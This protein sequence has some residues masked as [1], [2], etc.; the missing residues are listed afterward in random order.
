MVAKRSNLTDL[1]GE[2]PPVRVNRF[3]G[4]G[5]PLMIRQHVSGTLPTLK[6]FDGD[7]V[8]A[9]LS[10]PASISGAFLERRK[11]IMA[12]SRLTKDGKTDAID[13]SGRKALSAL[14]K[15]FEPL[16]KGLEK[17]E[18]QLRG[19]LRAVATPKPASDLGGVG[20]RPL[21]AI[22]AHAFLRRRSAGARLVLVR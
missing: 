16:L 22:R 17:H 6:Q 21:Q 2:L 12:D 15:W 9:E 11:A 14:S 7:A 5:V 8:A 1:F 4:S 10:E 3:D 19:E 20:G 13:A 18:E